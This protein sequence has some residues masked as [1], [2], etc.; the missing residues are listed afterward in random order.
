MPHLRKRLQLLGPALFTDEDLC[1]IG[2]SP[3]LS[4]PSPIEPL[5]SGGND[6]LD[7]IDTYDEGPVV[8]DDT[9]ASSEVS[10]PKVE[11]ID[12]R[13][14]WPDEI[15]HNNIYIKGSSIIRHPCDKSLES[16]PSFTIHNQRWLKRSTCWTYGNVTSDYSLPRAHNRSATGPKT[17]ELD[18]RRWI[19]AH[20]EDGSRMIISKMF[21]AVALT[22]MPRS[23]RSSEPYHGV[24]LFYT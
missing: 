24:A 22:G 10:A 18:G 9:P 16:C 4:G 5:P 12:L 17:D 7:E 3:V 13:P 14:L 15:S 1:G 2:V 21:L 6:G 8:H 19:L 23:S 20:F 11:P